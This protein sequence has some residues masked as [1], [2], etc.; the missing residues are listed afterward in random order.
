MPSDPLG[1]RPRLTCLPHGG[2]AVKVVAG[3]SSH[4]SPSAGSRQSGMS[5]AGRDIARSL[6]PILGHCVERDSGAASKLCGK[7]CRDG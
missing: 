3:L 2:L 6:G 7:E 4:R 5:P 1:P